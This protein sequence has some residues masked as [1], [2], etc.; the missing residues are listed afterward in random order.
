MIDLLEKTDTSGP[1]R[2][3]DPIHLTMQHEGEFRITMCGVKMHEVFLTGEAV[4]CETCL[5]KGK[6]IGIFS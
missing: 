4:T 6:S 3:K 5:I 1:P 2:A